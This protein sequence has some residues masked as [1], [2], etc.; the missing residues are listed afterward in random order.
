M[1]RFRKQQKNRSEKC[2]MF[3]KISNN[4]KRYNKRRVKNL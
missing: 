1:K 3:K 4:K 2:S